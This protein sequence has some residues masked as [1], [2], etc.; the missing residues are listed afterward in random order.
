METKKFKITQ[1]AFEEIKATIGNKPAES[2]G[3]LFGS[4]KD[5]IVT[6][7]LFDKNSI[8][9]P[10]SYTFNTGYLNPIIKKW[11]EENE[12]EL[13]GFIHSHP[14][15]LGRL[16]EPDKKYFAS[17]FKNIDVEQFLTPLVFS[18][19]DGGFKFIPLAYTKNGTVEQLELEI[20]SDSKKTTK[21]KPSKKRKIKKVY[22][23]KIVVNIQNTIKEVEIPQTEITPEIDEI[24]IKKKN[25]THL[26][27]FDF[28]KFYQVLFAFTLIVILGLLIVLI[29]SFYKYIIQQLLN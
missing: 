22:K 7:F 3:L 14:F 13:L 21:K 10:S 17:Q 29:P 25:R 1:S 6:R 8:N 26:D 18:A 9:T 4:R 19:K 23:N 2:G 5:F 12:L 27:D 24:K 15:G 16:S 28:F 11:W 20:I